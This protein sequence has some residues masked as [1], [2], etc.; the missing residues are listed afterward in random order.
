MIKVLP[1]LTSVDAILKLLVGRKDKTHINL[2]ISAST[3]ASESSRLQYAE[4]LDLDVKW[5]FRDFIH[6]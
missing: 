6:E 5:H 1:E 2:N 4:Q 3:Q